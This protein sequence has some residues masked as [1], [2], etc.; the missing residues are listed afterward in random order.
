[1]IAQVEQAPRR[2]FRYWFD[3]GLVEIGVDL[4]FLALMALFAVEGLA[5]DGSAWSG[6]SPSG[7]RWSS[8]AGWPCW[9]WHCERSRNG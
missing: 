4:L 9:A 2:A 3:D 6:F 1:M 7:C 5:P 8:S